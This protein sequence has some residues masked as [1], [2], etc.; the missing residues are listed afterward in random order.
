MPNTQHTKTGKESGSKVVISGGSTL[1][2]DSENMVSVAQMNL[3]LRTPATTPPASKKT[4]KNAELKAKL[5]LVAGALA[6]FQAAGGRVISKNVEATLP[7]GTV[8]RG[9]KLYL[10]AD[11]FGISKNATADGLEFDLV[12]E[13]K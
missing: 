11:G 6:D 10:V 2:L 8:I 7:S 12:A 3:S 13:E 5:D 1:P 4:A 9:I